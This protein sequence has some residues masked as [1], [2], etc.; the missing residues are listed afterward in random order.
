MNIEGFAFA[1]PEKEDIPELKD[2]FGKTFGESEEFLSAFF[3]LAFSEERAAALFR[4]GNPIAA[5][6]WFDCAF[7]DKKIAYIYGVA[8]DKEYRGRGIGSR[9]LNETHILLKAKGYAGAILVPQNE[10]LFSFYEKFGYEKCT[11][12]REFKAELKE[13]ALGTAEFVKEISK[14]EYAIERKKHLPEGAV[15]Q[16][17]ENL[18]FL[19]SYNRFFCGGG[20]VCAAAREKDRL[21][22]PEFLG[23]EGGACQVLAALGAKEGIFRTVGSGR[24]FTMYKSLTDEKTRP[25][26]FAFAFD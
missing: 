3:S 18:V 23:N 7:E 20:F 13:N 6:Y 24:V 14:E 2:L 19:A 5:L 1:S 16:E 15:I 22:C 26:Y 17:G 8:T 11:Q 10:G 25:A 4:L 9:L 21:F 12:H